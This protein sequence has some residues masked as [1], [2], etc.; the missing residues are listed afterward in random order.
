M[1]SGLQ[2]GRVISNGVPTGVRVATSMVHGGPPYA[3]NRPET[4]SV[5]APAI[6]RWCRPMCWQN[7]PEHLLPEELRDDNP[8]KI[9]REED[10]RARERD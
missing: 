10:G 5:G 2:A 3:A 4:T 6:E 9:L 7:M 1:W 8:L